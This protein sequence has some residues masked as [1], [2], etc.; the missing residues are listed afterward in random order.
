MFLEPSLGEQ[1]S[2][3]HS[4]DDLELFSSSQHCHFKV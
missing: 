3:G 4:Q 1:E 2:P